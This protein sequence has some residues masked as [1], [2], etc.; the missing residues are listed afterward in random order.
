MRELSALLDRYD[1][2]IR[3]AANWIVVKPE[4]PAHPFRRLAIESAL[5]KQEAA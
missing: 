2:D 5:R 3:D 1:V 4:A